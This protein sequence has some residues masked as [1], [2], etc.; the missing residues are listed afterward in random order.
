MKAL[1]PPISSRISPRVSLRLP[2]VLTLLIGALLACSGMGESEEDDGSEP[3]PPPPA[4]ADEVEPAAPTPEPPPPPQEEWESINVTL[5]V[6]VPIKQR[7]SIRQAA[8]ETIDAEL[9]KRGYTQA[10]DVDI[11]KMNC[12]RELCTSE[13]TARF[14]RK[15]KVTT[16]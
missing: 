8:S 10:K 15:K 13:V 6:S 7:T 16:P 5:T 4:P 1:T 3:P 2:F 14:I 9:K 12:A 11:G